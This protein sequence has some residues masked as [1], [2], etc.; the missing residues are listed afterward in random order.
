MT[1]WNFGTLTGHKS[2]RKNSNRSSLVSHGVD[3]VRMF[4]FFFGNGS[5]LITSLHDVIGEA[6]SSQLR[7]V[8]FQSFEELY[9]YS[10]PDNTYIVVNNS[11]VHLLDASL[12]SYYTSQ[13]LSQLRFDV[14]PALNE[15]ARQAGLTAVADNVVTVVAHVRTGDLISGPKGRIDHMH[16]ADDTR[17]HAKL[18]SADDYFDTF[19]SIKE[20]LLSMG[21][22]RFNFNAYTSTVSPNNTF[23]I[24]LYEEF[25]K[26]GIH[27]TIDSEIGSAEEVTG[28]VIKTLTKL[29]K[30]DILIIA[31]SMF[32]HVAGFYNP[33]CVLYE[34][35]DRAMPVFW[36]QYSPQRWVELRNA[37]YSDYNKMV[38]RS[39]MPI[40]LKKHQPKLSYEAK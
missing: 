27:L 13:Y 6:R 32:S 21:Y 3:K 15:V 30:A 11:T 5:R 20:I 2:R 38:L 4:D 22:S 39:K 14:S 24:K 16:P 36:Q 17:K 18:L 19:D 35:Y 28:A 10:P 34:K 1:G 31:S 12:D 7:V 40:C 29:M 9:Q 37:S 33:S 25:R 8:Q 23:D 26:R